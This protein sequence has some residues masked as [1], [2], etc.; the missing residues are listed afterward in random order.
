MG[1]RLYIAKKKYKDNAIEKRLILPIAIEKSFDED[2]GTYFQNYTFVK[3]MGF[4]D[5]LH[6]YRDPIAEIILKGTDK[7]ISKEIIDIYGADLLH[8]EDD[9]ADKIGELK[10]EDILTY[11][12]LIHNEMIE[13]YKEINTDEVKQ[14]RWLKTAYS[15]ACT[16]ET[17]KEFCKE[18]NGELQIPYAVQNSREYLLLQLTELYNDT[19]WEKECLVIYGW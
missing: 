3:K 13:Y 2:E 12:L 15:K 8:Q 19:D 18:H 1:Y 16:W 10:K 17:S 4:E 7:Y 9:S 5:I 11:I 6:L 14:D